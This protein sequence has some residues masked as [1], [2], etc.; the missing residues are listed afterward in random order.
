MG[1]VSDLTTLHPKEAAAAVNSLTDEQALAFLYDWDE[2]ARWNQIMPSSL[3]WQYW[4]IQAGRGFGKTR[5]GAETVR[6]VVEGGQYKR[7]ALVGRTAADCRDTMVEGESGI[8][9]V[10]PPHQRPKYEPSKRRITF[11]NGVKATTYSAE[12]PDSLRGPQ[13]DFAWCDELAAWQYEEAWDQLLFGLRLGENPR[14]VITT[15][16]RPTKIIRELMKD[17]LTVI[18]RGNTYDNIDNLAPAFL[19]AIIKKYEGTRLGR[20]EIEA[21][22]LEDNPD[23]LWSR[24]IID[25]LR[26]RTVPEGVELVHVIVGVDPAVTN[27]KKSDSTGIV[28]AAKGSDSHFYVLSDKTTKDTPK[29]WAGAAIRQY[30][31]WQADKIIG[32]VNNGG[33]LVAEVINTVDSTVAFGSVRASRGKIVRAEPISALYEKGIVHHVGIF[34]ELEDEMCDWVPGEKSPDRMDALVWALTELLGSTDIFIA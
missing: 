17:K 19:N 18:S 21:E 11:H 2:W 26:V 20:Q 30:H 15:T 10:F 7:I 4:L 16:P 6:K 34:G 22:L 28:V 33:D 1:I 8:L 27:N 31:L 14:A 29:E 13:H 23:A 12:K 5:T 32:E 9:E 3:N 24:S 25:D